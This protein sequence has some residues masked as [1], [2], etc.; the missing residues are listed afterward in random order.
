MINII[1]S[2]LNTLSKLN[3]YQEK[4][5]LIM[6]QNGD[7]EQSIKDLQELIDDG[8]LPKLGKI[9]KKQEEIGN[10]AIGS[11]QCFV[12]VQYV[13]LVVGQP[14]PN[15]MLQFQEGITGYVMFRGKNFG[16]KQNEQYGIF[17]LQVEILC[18]IIKVGVNLFLKKSLILQLRKVKIVV[19]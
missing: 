2:N 8:P 16:I 19:V 10:F 11:C 6:K 15:R 14:I 12:D 3:L 5:D 9:T 13:L 4:L 7:S 17:A 18:I 1:D